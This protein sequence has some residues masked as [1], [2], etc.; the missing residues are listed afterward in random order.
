MVR[1]G[2]DEGHDA[3]ASDERTPLVPGDPD[4]LAPSTRSYDGRRGG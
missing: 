1:E 2:L 4:H 3:C